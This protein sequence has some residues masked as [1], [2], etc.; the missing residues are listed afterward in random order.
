MSRSR[1]LVLAPIPTLIL[2]MAWA[3]GPSATT[4]VHASAPAVSADAAQAD[5]DLE[6]FMG[7][8][9]RY[10]TLHCRL[11]AVLP[12]LEMTSDPEEICAACDALGR[13]VREARADAR[14]GDIFTPEAAA[15][16]RTRLSAALHGRDVVA[17]VAEL[18]EEREEVPEF[19]AFQP[20]VHG[21][22]PGPIPPGMMPPSLLRALPRLPEMLE[23]RLVRHAL[24]LWDPHAGLIVDFVPGALPAR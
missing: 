4:T 3:L 15:V 8:V 9:E 23:Y 2:V 21:E 5:R 1:A 17:F 16:I 11:E 22:F 10:A 18:N 13:A 6:D 19:A 14:Q 12:P 24:L 20:R 7:H